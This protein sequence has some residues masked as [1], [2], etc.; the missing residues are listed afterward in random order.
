MFGLINKNIIFNYTLLSGGCEAKVESVYF[1][2]KNNFGYFPCAPFL[3]RET[4]KAALFPS[5]RPL[6]NSNQYSF[7]IRLCQ[8]DILL[9]VSVLSVVMVQILVVRE[10]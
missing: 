7:Q 9:S 10:C 8:M 1:D 4:E 3:R 2:F 6:T 5:F